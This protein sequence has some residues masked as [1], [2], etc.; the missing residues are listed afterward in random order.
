M[1]SVVE[2][3]FVNVTQKT[4]VSFTIRKSLEPLSLMAKTAP[5]EASSTLSRLS[6]NRPRKMPD[7]GSYL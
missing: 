2:F 4:R 6:F 3:A 5:E 1:I 7:C